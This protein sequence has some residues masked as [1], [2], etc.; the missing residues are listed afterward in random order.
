MQVSVNRADRHRS[1]EEAA[2]TAVEQLGDRKLSDAEWARVRTRLLEFTEILRAW[3]RTT[4]GPRRGKVE[5]ICQRE[6]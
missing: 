6:P 3:D 2:R 5:K 4:A 1:H